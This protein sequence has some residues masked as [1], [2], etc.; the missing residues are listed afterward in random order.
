MPILP[1]YACEEA[2][3]GYFEPKNHQAQST[4]AYVIDLSGLVCRVC[5]LCR[6]FHNIWAIDVTHQV[7]QY[8][9]Q[10]NVEFFRHTLRGRTA[11]LDG[12]IH[13]ITALLRR[14]SVRAGVL[15]KILIYTRLCP[16]PRLAQK[17]GPNPEKGFKGLNDNKGAGCNWRRYHLDQ[18]PRLQP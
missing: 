4:V 3:K 17:N 18:M 7:V 16:Q 11:D 2:L 5:R 10:G 1:L 8:P 12:I 13:S 9:D 14:T 6:L 15:P